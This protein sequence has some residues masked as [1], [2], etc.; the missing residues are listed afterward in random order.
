MQKEISRMIYKQTSEIL[1]INARLKHFEREERI[2]EVFLVEASLLFK[3]S[4]DSEYHPN[5]YLTF[6]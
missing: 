6:K 3:N 2:P 5:N 1:F 4:P